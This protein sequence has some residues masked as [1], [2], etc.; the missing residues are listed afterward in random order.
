MDEQRKK[1]QSI[2]ALNERLY[3][4][5][6]EFKQRD[7]RK[8]HGRK[9]E[10]RHDFEY[11]EKKKSKNKLRLPKSLFQKI[12][13]FS[14][15]L[16][17]G[18]VIFAG[19]SLYTKKQEVST[20]YISMDILGQ[21]FVDG[22]ETLELQVRVQNFNDK[23][24]ELPDLVLSYPKD[25]SEKGE[26][27]FLRRSLPDLEK[28][29]RA[30]EE[31]N[32]VL[33]GK[34]GDTRNIHATLEYR[35]EGSSAI[36]IKEF[37]HEVIIRST[38]TDISITAPKEIVQGQDFELEVDIQ[39]NSTKQLNNL[40]LNIQYPLGFEFISSNVEPSYS[41]HMWYFD[42]LDETKENKI[43]IKGKINAL[44]GQGKTFSAILGKQ[45]FAQKNEI[46]TIF[47]K[48]THTIDIQQSFI[49]PRI[50]V[51][52]NNSGEYSVRGGGDLD[53]EIDF[54]NTLKT[55]LTDAKIIAHLEG[56]LY[57]KE[58]VLLQN[59]EYNSNLNQIIWDKE[60][61]EELKVLEPGEKGSLSFSLKTKELVNKSEVLQ[62]PKLLIKLDVSGTELNGE[63]REA[64]SVARTEVVANSDIAL[65]AKTLYH[66]GPFKN[67]GPIP[68]R[69]GEE[70]NYT[71]TLQV[72]N[73]SNDVEKGKVT[74]SLPSYVS[75]L[76]A[77]SPSV[78]RQNLSY[79]EVKRE[80]TWNIGNIPAKTGVGF[81]QPRQVSFQI[82]VLPSLSHYDQIIPLTKDLVLSGT[83]TFTKVDLRY[84]KPQLTT[85][86]KEDSDSKTG[87]GR[88][89]K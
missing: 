45:N 62:N 9:I 59:G 79:N 29:K 42:H 12:F 58:G 53:I 43:L 61:F 41:S 30:T 38:P 37:D 52:G 56:D 68:P 6:Q 69:V 83:D 84:K 22:G 80:L 55:S 24:L 28:G 36:F 57:T 4:K 85:S 15:F 44:A 2:D 1:Q 19:F 64:F 25:S 34:E 47:N 7:R 40:L 54:E 65:I 5:N 18:T 78:E 48:A 49:T 76:G 71:I 39:S 81:T 35:I 51:N 77:I 72:T 17:I 21:P 23:K 82:K 89:Q 86:L 66:D 50:I 63:F 32:I 74:T 73:S 3:Y 46:E 70:T 33:F 27:V 20:D 16:F 11:Q 8:I 14:L 67:Y 60:S 75:W 10:L 13:F 31:F 26:E 87:D 88:V